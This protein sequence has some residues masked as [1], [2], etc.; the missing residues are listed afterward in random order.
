MTPGRRR[1]SDE[2]LAE[3]VR[4]MSSI[5]VLGAKGP[6]RALEPSSSIPT[7]LEQRGYEILRI[8]PV[9]AAE[10]GS[11]ALESVADLPRQVDVLDVFRR[12][13]AIPGHVDEILALPAELRPKTVWLQS[14][15]RHDEA[16]QR[17]IDVGIDVV[18]DACLGVLASRY[19]RRAA[20]S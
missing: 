14:G 1:T 20:D 18:Q 9:L 3:V 19:G 6:D 2:E 4:G 7:M 13:A 16:T 12:P 5:A 15:I 8:S 17:L 10:P 11:D